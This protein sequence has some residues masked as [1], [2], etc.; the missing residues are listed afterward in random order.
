MPVAF[1]ALVMGACAMGISPVFVRF[2]DVGPFTSAFWRVGLAVPLLLAWV[3]YEQKRRSKPLRGALKLDWAVILS[4]A[5]FAGDLFF[6]HLAILNTTMANATLFSCLAPIWVAMLSGLVIGEKVPKVAFAGLFFCLIGAGLL[7]GGS[8]TAAPERV[9]GDLYGLV[10]SF[11]FGIYFLAIRVARRSHGAWELTL[12]S[13]TVTAIILFVIA[14][15]AEDQLFPKTASGAASLLAM[16][17]FSH[18]GGQG[19]LT[20]ALGVMSAAF[21]SLVIFM[22]AVAAAIA[23][24][25]I[26]S[27]KLS[28]SQLFGGSLI[29]LGIWIARPRPEPAS[30]ALTSPT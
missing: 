3:A 17:W 26:F 29:L 10:T 19:L 23:G 22:E 27:E 24:W 16:S 18:I 6:W 30:D 2:A 4:G 1:A 12:K 15:L 9:T 13:T 20:V 28:L 21:S 14:I 25:L 5:F 11:F 8:Y 7:I